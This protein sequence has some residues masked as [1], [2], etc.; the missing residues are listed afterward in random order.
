M[1][2]RCFYILFFIQIF[3]SN[4]SFAKWLCDMNFSAEG[5]GAQFFVGKFLIQGKG[6]VFCRSK[7]DNEELKYPVIV[8]FDAS[9]LAPRFAAGILKFSGSSVDIS[10]PENLNPSDLLGMYYISDSQFSVAKGFG[11]FH[12]IKSNL[13]GLSIQLNLQ[14]IEGYGF[15]IGFSQF[16]IELNYSEI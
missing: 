12:G 8:K 4:L 11:Y 6:I 3:F 9:L 15:D 1:K 2:K 5:S 13:D 10:V 14:K 16:V 7:E